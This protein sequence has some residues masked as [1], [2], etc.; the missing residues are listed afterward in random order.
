MFH[1]D[2]GNSLV[3]HGLWLDLVTDEGAVVFPE[4]CSES[5]AMDIEEFS[6]ELNKKMRKYYVDVG[7]DLY[8]HEWEKHGTCMK[9]YTPEKYF[10]KVFELFDEYKPY[11]KFIED[12]A[13]RTL[14]YSLV[15]ENF[16]K[17]SK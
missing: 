6:P 2:L 14:P 11:S 13:G 12:N 8:R 4:F 7:Y 1:S 9:G 10:S 17:D 15:Q 3:P 16:I 5:A